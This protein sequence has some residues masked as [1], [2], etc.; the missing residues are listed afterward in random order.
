M[1][2]DYRVLMSTTSDLKRER[3]TASRAVHMANCIPIAMENWTATTKTPEQTVRE[4]LC[5]CQF[6]VL[7]TGASYGDRVPLADPI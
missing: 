7:L 2:G 4:K 6:F 1:N 3:E 5:P